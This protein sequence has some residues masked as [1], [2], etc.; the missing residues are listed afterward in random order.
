MELA[1]TGR[2]GDGCFNEA[3]SFLSS[4][5]SITLSA[6]LSIRASAFCA[7]L[8]TIRVICVTLQS[9][10]KPICA[11]H[12]AVRK[13]FV[14]IHRRC[15]PYT[16]WRFLWALIACASVHERSN[17]HPLN[18]RVCRDSCYFFRLGAASTNFNRWVEQAGLWHC[19]Q[20]SFCFCLS[21][22]VVSCNTFRYVFYCSSMLTVFFFFFFFY[23]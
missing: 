12:W 7:P 1:W 16:S 6:N 17:K 21:F 11:F 23:Q 19:S 9:T 13:P 15:Y 2:A 3:W 14:P 5:N 20:F 4:R 10:S 18:S 8:A 22:A